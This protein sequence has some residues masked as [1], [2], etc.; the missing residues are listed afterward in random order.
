MLTFTQALCLNKKNRY[1]IIE[2]CLLGLQPGQ[3]VKIAMTSLNGDGHAMVMGKT[4]NNTFYLYD[5]NC[6]KDSDVKQVVKSIKDVIDVLDKNYNTMII[7]DPKPL[8]NRTLNKLNKSNAQI[9]RL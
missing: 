6:V 8:I 2:N 9:T 4:D 1:D 3:F 5:D 7:I